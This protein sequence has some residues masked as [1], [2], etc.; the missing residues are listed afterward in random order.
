MSGLRATEDSVERWG[1]LSICDVFAQVPGE[2][3]VVSKDDWA[4]T[5]TGPEVMRVS[6]AQI[7]EVGLSV[8]SS[9]RAAF[10]TA[11]T[12]RSSGP[13]ILVERPDRSG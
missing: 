13:S 5:A 8:I 11:M 2:H 10:D 9:N 7:G 4:W 12:L 3:D 1:R 6:T